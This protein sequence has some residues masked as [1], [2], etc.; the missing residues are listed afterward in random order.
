VLSLVG[1][2]SL[3][4]LIV[5]TAIRSLT[6]DYVASR[7]ADD[8][9]SVL[10]LLTFTSDGRPIIE[11]SRFDPSYHRPFSGHYYEIRTASGYTLSSRSLWDAEL[12]VS[13]MPVGKTTRVHR[14]G[15]KG[16]RLLG[17]AN[18]F[19][20]QGHAVTIVVAEDLAP[21]K[22]ELGQFQQQYMLASLG[23]LG[24]L[25]AVQQLIVRLGF[26]PLQRVRQDI[27]RLEQGEIS[28][29][30][31]AVPTEVRPLVQEMNRLLE[32]LEQRLRRSRHALGNLA[33]ALKTPLT[34]VMQL[35]NGEDFRVVPQ[36]R[37]QLIEHTTV[38]HHRLERELRRAR[39]AGAAPPSQRLRLAEE[40]PALVDVLHRIYQDKALKITYG[41]APQAAVVG[42]REDLLELLGNLLDNACKWAHHQVRVTIQGQPGLRV[43]VEDDGPGCP[44]TVLRQL[45]ERGVRID[46]STP[47]YGLGL[48]IV[49]DIVEQ[50][51]GDISFR[52]SR[53][54]G[55]FEV[56]V[57]LTNTGTRVS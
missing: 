18:G 44:S 16:Q 41:I 9:A 28:Q 38:L 7:L 10:A 26:R 6:E 11:A 46:E 33:H 24:L 48:A 5:S 4:W 19:N 56:C 40:L 36:A 32:V 21:L 52:R 12:T 3:Q 53:Q 42:D 29:L 2:F 25:I 13:W 20:K 23:I 17:L 1:L 22:A 50:Y 55:G 34:L 51:S 57:T 15:P 35:A 31:E 14:A 27:T 8:T 45:A 30:E 37:Q 43:V 49:K 54:L 39:L 47:G